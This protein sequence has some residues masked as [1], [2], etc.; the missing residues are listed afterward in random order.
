VAVWG[1]IPL[2]INH[3]ERFWPFLIKALRCRR[4]GLFLNSDGM[5]AIKAG[6]NTWS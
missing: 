3:C 4:A 2:R 5:D 1:G 6:E